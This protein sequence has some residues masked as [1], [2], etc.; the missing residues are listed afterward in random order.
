MLEDVG[1]A[2]RELTNR[3]LEA[4]P[5]VVK[6]TCRLDGRG[7]LPVKAMKH[8]VLA[9]ENSLHV[10]DP[11]S[12]NQRLASIINS[13]VRSESAARSSTAPCR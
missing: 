9:A 5:A 7:S 8:A 6:D 10:L 2:A 11:L 1:T 12:A 3:L 13:S 4:A